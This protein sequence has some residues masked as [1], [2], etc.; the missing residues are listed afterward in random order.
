MLLR[1]GLHLKSPR[2][3]KHDL[4]RGRLGEFSSTPFSLSMFSSPYGNGSKALILEIDSIMKS[5][6]MR[7][8]YV[9]AG[10]EIA[11]FLQGLK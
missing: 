10:L 11:A 6:R 9:V 8:L 1:S 4:D 5:L 7:A 2:A 3:V